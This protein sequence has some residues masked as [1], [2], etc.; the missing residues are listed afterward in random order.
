MKYQVHAFGRT[1]KTA[2]MFRRIMIFMKKT[3]LYDRHCEL[4]GKNC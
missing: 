3:P 2:I 1:V 4:G